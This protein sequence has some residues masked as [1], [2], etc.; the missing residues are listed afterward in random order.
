MINA[1]LP[2]RVAYSIAFS[3]IDDI[4]WVMQLIEEE[5]NSIPPLFSENDNNSNDEVAVSSSAVGETNA[6]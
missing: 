6:V 2:K 5:Q 4:E 3:C 1:E